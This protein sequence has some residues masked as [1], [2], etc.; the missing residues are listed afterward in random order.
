[1]MFFDQKQEKAFKH[2]L[3]H[4]WKD[5]EKNYNRFE[6]KYTGQCRARAL[7]ILDLHTKWY[8]SFDGMLEL[9]ENF[10]KREMI[11]LTQI[12]TRLAQLLEELNAGDAI[13]KDSSEDVMT[14]LSDMENSVR[15]LMEIISQSIQNTPTVQAVKTIANQMQEE[16]L[17][18]EEAHQNFYQLK[19]TLMGTNPPV[20]RRIQV[21]ATTDLEEFHEILQ[22]TMGWQD[23]HLHAF[24]ID[25]V[26]YGEPDPFLESDM[27]DEGDVRLHQVINSSGQKFF[28]E[29]DF[30]D[31]WEHEIL[32]EKIIE[33]KPGQNY[34]ICLKGKGACPP[35]DCGGIPGYQ[36]LLRIIKDP[37][38]PEY[39][40]MMEWLDEPFDPNAFSLEE[41]NE[42]LRKF[43]ISI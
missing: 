12:M 20:W 40:E 24:H 27:E 35:E 32:V 13:P 34:P 21:P 38:H 14:M 33:R 9:P 1:M 31:S 39:E 30:G 8:R 22:D 11:A 15:A 37:K 19:I 29:Y 16:F 3:N 28:Y 25:G 7:E 4:L 42:H 26:E 5:V 23:C 43:S 6:D 41:I 17:S 10:P 36:E 2:H 18:E